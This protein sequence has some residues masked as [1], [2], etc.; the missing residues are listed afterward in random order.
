MG[1]ARAVSYVLEVIPSEAVLQSEPGTSAGD[2]P[3]QGRSLGP[4]RRTRALGM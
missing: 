1:K 2:I 3:A 4:R